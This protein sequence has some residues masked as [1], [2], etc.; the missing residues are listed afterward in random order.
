[1]GPGGA[2]AS[3]GG[4][5]RTAARRERRA[6]SRPLIA[7]NPNFPSRTISASGRR[8]FGA[9]RA[10]AQS[11]SYD[12]SPRFPTATRTWSMEVAGLR[13]AAAVTAFL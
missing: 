12:G 3:A 9:S 5:D 4:P 6:A 10:F 11:G 1:M 8:S 7:R 2:G 13:W